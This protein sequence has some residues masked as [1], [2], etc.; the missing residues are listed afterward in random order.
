MNKQISFARKE[1]FSSYQK[2]SLIHFWDSFETLKSAEEWKAKKLIQSKWDK[3]TEL[4]H[5]FRRLMIVK[6]NVFIHPHRIQR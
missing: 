3:I 1:K 5:L 2:S 6:L 4:M